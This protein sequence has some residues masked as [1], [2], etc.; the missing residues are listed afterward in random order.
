M[1]LEI[2][3]DIINTLAKNLRELLRTKRQILFSE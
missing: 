3:D 1:E 2:L